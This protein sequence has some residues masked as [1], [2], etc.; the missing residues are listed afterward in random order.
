M[1]NLIT[2]REYE[3]K[4]KNEVIHLIRLNTPKYFATGEEED[5]NEYLEIKRELYYVLL[6]NEKIVGCGGI[7]FAEKKTIGKISWDIFHP[8]YQ[9]KSLGTRLLN[10]RIERLRAFKSV[11]KI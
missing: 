7:N 1:T 9:G 11:K 6:S 10:Y 3:S 8:E 4:D 2:I 5:L